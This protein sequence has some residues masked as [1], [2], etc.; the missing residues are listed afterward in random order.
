MRDETVLA[1]WTF[2]NP[3]LARI[4]PPAFERMNFANFA[5]VAVAK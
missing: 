3:R 5:G 1:P 4:A 2:R